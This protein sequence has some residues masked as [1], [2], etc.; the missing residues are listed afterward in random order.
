MRAGICYD[1]SMSSAEQ[2]LPFAKKAFLLLFTVNL[3]NYIDRYVLPAVFP[4]IQ[5][6]LHISDTMLGLLASS[7]ML[8]YMVFAPLAGFM[9][10]KWLRP[11]LMGTAALIWSAA[12]SCAGFA[13]GYGTL[14]AARSA[15]GIGEA[16]FVTIAQSYVAELFSPKRR[17]SVMALF[18]LV[19][20]VGSAIGYILGGVLGNH[21]GWRAAFLILGIP[22]ALLGAAVM[23]LPDP[24]HQRAQMDRAP[25]L[26]DYTALLKNKIFLSCSFTQ[27]AATFTVGGLSAWMPTY[28]VRYFGY[29]VAKAGMVFGGMTVTAGIIGT[30]LG[31]WLGDKLLERSRRAYFTVACASLALAA[32]CALATVFAK[33]QQFSLLFLFLA[34]TCVF[35]HGGPMN[36]AIVN[37]TERNVRA[38]AFAVNIFIIH[39]FGDAV[40]PFIIGAISDAASLR[41]AV[42]ACALML[43]PAAGIAFLGGH[44]ESKLETTVT[45]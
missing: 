6:D 25:A 41:F 23:L 3:F 14:M 7:F 1:I 26:S 31:G 29:N 15:V 24:R 4:L 11:R 45:V 18:T 35:M 21:F 9:G 13:G 20:P 16:G 32:P 34:E 27:A 19:I 37:R 2:D 22:G 44:F 30:C 12:T 39:A 5:A 42:A 43:L 17:A 10:D 36:A 40:S 28:F 8:V 33:N 38:M